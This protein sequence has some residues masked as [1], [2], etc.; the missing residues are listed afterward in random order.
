MERLMMN[1]KNIAGM[2]VERAV[3]GALDYAELAHL[4]LSPDQI[5]DFSVNANPYGPSPLV[6]EAIIR[7]MLDRYP[8]RECLHLR[9]ALLDYEWPSSKLELASIVCGN[10]ASELIW[11]I[12][13]AYLQPDQK[14]AIIG[15]TFGEYR[16]ASLATRALVIEMQ[17]QPA[18]QFH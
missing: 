5:L 6:V 10:G 8:D 15:P 16:A 1:D 7:V 17:A 11:A 4:G 18:T 3:H 14:A 9:Q 2:H 13:R 12:A